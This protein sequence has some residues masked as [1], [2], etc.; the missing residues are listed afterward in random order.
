MSKI[1]TRTFRVRWGELDSSGTVS[2]AHYVHYF[3]K[4]LGIGASPLVWM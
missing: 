3:I 2:P 1:Y 4:P